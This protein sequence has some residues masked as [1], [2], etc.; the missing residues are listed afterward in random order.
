VIRF[1]FDYLSPYAYLAWTQI[2]AV[3]AR[4]GRPVEPVPVLFAALL[5][6]AGTKGPA[7]VPAKRS[8]LFAD[9]LRSA[10]RLGVPLVPPPTHPFHPLLALR[11]SSV[12]LA[13]A[14]RTRLVDALFAAAWGGGASGVHG[15]EDPGGVAAIATAVGLDGPAVVAAA[16]TAE[17]KDRLRRETD[18]AIAGGAFGVPTMFVDGELFWGLDSLANL[19][20]HLRGDSPPEL[21]ERARWS[22]LTSSAQRRT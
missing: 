4:H 7:E 8:Y 3:A 6:A 2:H 12:E 20:Q 9:C 11:V 15:V 18:A 13:L 22:T 19:E 14:E 5:G 21:A 1:C 10:H 16:A 17:V